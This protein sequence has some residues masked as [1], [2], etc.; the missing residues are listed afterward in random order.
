MFFKKKSAAASQQNA[1]FFVAYRD[2]D[3]N[4]P[5]TVHIDA[6]QI[7]SPAHGGL[8]LADFARHMARAMAQA[9]KADGEEA[10][11]TAIL[12]LFQAE[13]DNPTGP[14]HGSIRN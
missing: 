5:V 11:L 7:E 1:P 4:G 6:D 10:A 13:I 12:E 9:G 8:M 2:A 3:P 14:V